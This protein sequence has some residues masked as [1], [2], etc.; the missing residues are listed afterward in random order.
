MATAVHGAALS[1]HADSA[2]DPVASPVLQRELPGIADAFNEQHMRDWLQVA[3]FDQQHAYHPIDNCEVEQATYLSGEGCVVRYLLTLGGAGAPSEPL[4]VSGYVF[5]DAERAAAFF[6]ERLEPLA[7]RAGNTPFARPIALRDSP[8]MVV[9]AYPIDADVPELI[10]ANDGALMRAR[11]APYLGA[12]APAGAQ[13]VSCRAELVDYGR[14]RRATLRYYLG[15]DGAADTIVYGKLTGD[16]SGALAG[17]VSAAL[18]E[19]GQHGATGARFGAPRVLDW[20]PD[21]KLSLLETLPGKDIIGDLLKARLRDKP[22]PSGVPSLEEAVEAC[23]RIA[24]ALHTSGVALGPARTPADELGRLS[25]AHAQVQ[26]ISP[27]L[28]ALL[29]PWYDRLVAAEA[30]S[31]ALAL[32]FNHGDFTAGQVLFDGHACGLI[33]FDSV[34]QAEPALDIAQ[35]LTYLTVG[36][37][38]SKRTA[39]E[40]RAIFADLT[41]RF[42]NTYLATAGY[43]E[44]DASRLMARVEVYRGISLLR[45]VLRSW[46]KMKPGRIAGALAMMQEALAPL[47]A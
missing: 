14:Q 11:L 45:R 8:A 29:A 26:R 35:F 12:I 24:A 7:A 39:E 32:C 20:L 21:L 36:G 13:I 33:D 23:A 37:Q 28:G 30:Q 9:F 15:L 40:T 19:L 3:L 44:G 27:E 22:V 46:Q 42:V 38:K 18:R 1:T 2:I 10:D 16:G 25:A 41:A 31:Q 47:G 43:S 6:H 34:C 4:L 17:D 5:G